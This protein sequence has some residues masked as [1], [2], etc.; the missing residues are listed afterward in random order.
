MIKRMT[1]LMSKDFTQSLNKIN[2]NQFSSM[3]G[4]VS[5]GKKNNPTQFEWEDKNLFNYVDLKFE[6]IKIY[7]RTIGQ[8]NDDIYSLISPVN[9]IIDQFN[10]RNINY[11]SFFKAYKKL[12]NNIDKALQN[13]NYSVHYEDFYTHFKESSFS[14]IKGV[15]GLGKSHFLWECQKRIKSNKKYESLFIYG[16]FFKDFE[17]IPWDYIISYSKHKE[18]LL[19]VDGVNEISDINQRKMLYE[20]IKILKNCNFARV[21]ISYRT[22]S[23]TSLI[24]G[25]QEEQYID[26]LMGNVIYFQ[27]VDFDS[28]LYQIIRNY[29]VDFSYYYHILYTN[30]PM[31]IKMLIEGNIF[32]DKDLIDKFKQFP[33]ISMTTIYERY[34]LS[35]CRKLWKSQKEKYWSEI[36]S[37]CK[38]MFDSNRI[39]FT[40]EDFSSKELNYKKFIDDLKNGGYLSTYDNKKYF[41]SLE[42]LSNYLIAR[43][44][45]DE[46][47]EKSIDDVAKAYNL[48]ALS[49]P[50]IKQILLSV[51]VEKYHDN[52]K[53]F[54]EFLRKVKPK[55]SYETLSNIVITDISIREEIQKNIPINNPFDLFS[56]LG[57]L[58]NR[59]FNCESYFF[60]YVI[61][62]KVKIM[63]P[64]IYSDKSEVIRR[65]KCIL[66]N[67]NGMY[68]VADNSIEFFKFA[69]V[70]LLIPDER[71]ND[72]SEKII[73]DLIESCDGDFKEIVFSILDSNTSP[74]LKRSLYNVLCHLSTKARFKYSNAFRQIKSNKNF[75]NA[76][77]LNNYSELVLQK[78]FAYVEFNK[79]NLFK[80]YENKLDVIA[81]S[82]EEYKTMGGIIGHIRLS[83]LFYSLNMENYNE[84]KLNFNLL[85]VDKKRILEF[86][87]I[88]NVLIE[89]YNKCVCSICVDDNY[90]SE[91]LQVLKNQI[92][93]HYDLFDQKKLFFGFVY[94]L[95]KQFEYYDITDEDIKWYKDKFYSGRYS[96]YPDNVSVILSI[97]VEEYIGSLMCNYFNDDCAISYWKDS[98]KLYIGF[99]PIEY[100][101]EQTSLSSPLS[102]YNETISNLDNMV[103][104]RINDSYKNKRNK[105][106]A[107][108]KNLSLKNCRNVLKPYILNK[109][110][111]VLLSAYISPHYYYENVKKKNRDYSEECLIIHCATKY[112]KNKNLIV[113]RYKTIEIQRYTGAI[114]DY[115]KRKCDFCKNINSIKDN[116]DV[117][118]ETNLVF[119]P[120]FLINTLELHYDKRISAWVDDDSNVVILCNNDVYY[121]YEN[122]IGHSIYINK[123]YLDANKSKLQL[124]YYVYTEKIS[125]DTGCYSDKS[126]MHLL[127]KNGRIL[128][129]NKNTGGRVDAPFVP[130]KKCIDCPIYQ[131]YTSRK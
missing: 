77:V 121:R 130:H 106:W 38:K 92:F 73:L 14:S 5:N 103:I 62:N 8:K 33:I 93:Q 59:L 56:K 124:Y 75:I 123:D 37:I 51:I 127:I 28:S 1:K 82:F 88:V 95:K 9:S 110:S 84:L 108:N 20:K 105:K 32:N 97:A 107:D 87:K 55:F 39:Y 131:Y 100:F 69:C 58:P 53:G 104:A 25:V 96:I 50:T 27:G 40:K 113:D 6:D 24:E 63:K 23:L 35:A 86:N 116:T 43:S 120:S 114:Y 17:S 44:F 118:D 79:T 71:I 90:F 119:P 102:S 11:K 22:Y 26:E 109:Q 13:E 4:F 111:W 45:N 21:F 125:Y 68:F 80:K 15:G 48:K 76:K 29:K 52:Y 65:L 61:L 83:K 3:T 46:I 7:T 64:G 117:F 42:Q 98:E 112:N 19:V 57:G 18:F 115:D 31:Q 41:F 91:I 99:K 54:I 66:H 122:Y 128:K 34:I 47:K 70:C 78:P 10:N 36:K 2:K 67:I 60:N 12:Q 89:K 16:K 126:N 49:F 30:N 101:E 74:L 129:C 72:L 85:N 81:T 94:H